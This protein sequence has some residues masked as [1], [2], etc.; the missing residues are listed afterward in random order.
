LQ[1]NAN[2]ADGDYDVRNRWYN[3]GGIGK[4]KSRYQPNKSAKVRISVGVIPPA[5]EQI[6]EGLDNLQLNLAALVRAHDKPQT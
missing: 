2:T 6:I 4:N 5:D 3:H 1:K